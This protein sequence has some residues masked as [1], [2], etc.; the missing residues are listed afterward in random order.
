V[1]R[2]LRPRGIWL[3]IWGA[4]QATDPLNAINVAKLLW[5]LVH[6][7]YIWGDTR[8]HVMVSPL[9]IF[10]WVNQK[11]SRGESLIIHQE[12]LPTHLEGQRLQVMPYLP[13]S[14]R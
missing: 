2:L 6:S 4:T 3:T 12:S 14:L 5:D 1:K 8:Q 9:P 13:Q 7:K 10:R 11:P